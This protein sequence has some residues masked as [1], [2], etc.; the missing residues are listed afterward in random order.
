MYTGKHIYYCCSEEKY[1][2]ENI[3]SL[4]FHVIFVSACDVSENFVMQ[5]YKCMNMICCSVQKRNA[6][7]DS[8]TKQNVLNNK[9]IKTFMS[10]SKKKY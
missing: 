10:S 7:I 3:Y 9:N 6:Y 8:L 4:V 5:K 2:V 1:S